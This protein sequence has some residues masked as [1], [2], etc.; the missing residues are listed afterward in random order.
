MARRL[1]QH[2]SAQSTPTSSGQRQSRSA[3][4]RTSSTIKNPASTATNRRQHRVATTRSQQLPS[5]PLTRRTERQLVEDEDAE[6]PSV[7]DSDDHR[8]RHPRIN[9]NG[10]QRL[11]RTRRRHGQAQPDRSPR[12]ARSRSPHRRRN[13]AT[14][15]PRQ[16]GLSVSSDAERDEHRQRHS[17]G[18]SSSS[19]SSSLSSSTSSLPSVQA[20]AS[21]SASSSPSCHHTRHARRRAH[22]HLRRHHRYHHY[23]R[24]YGYS[25]RESHSPT[26]FVSCAPPPHNRIISKIRRGK[27]ID[28][29]YLLPAVD[30]IVPVQ[31][32][33]PPVAKRCHQKSPPPRKVTDFQTWM[34]AWNRFLIIAT[35][36]TPSRSLELVQYQ[37]LVSHLFQAY[38][39]TS[40]H[41]L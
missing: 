4:Q 31:A 15:S 34:E 39:H 19:R 25:H 33:Q 13:R 1:H 9:S 20:S 8:R 18:S 3:R 7:D 23:H 30:D 11:P 40:S 29:D 10:H 35:H 38:P 21:S 28:F 14:R 26:P 32:T 6:D 17:R 24:R 5:R 37:V 22:R 41:S 36:H 16:R 27:Y 2:L 12:L